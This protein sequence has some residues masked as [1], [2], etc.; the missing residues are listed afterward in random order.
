M[1]DVYKANVTKP[2][3]FSKSILKYSRKISEITIKWISVK[4]YDTDQAYVDK[5]DFFEME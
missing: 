2:R 3:I 5:R 4:S 1:L